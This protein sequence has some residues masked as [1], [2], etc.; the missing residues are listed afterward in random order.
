MNNMREKAREELDPQIWAKKKVYIK[1]ELNLNLNQFLS[2]QTYAS[3]TQ[4]LDLTYLQ[5]FAKCLPELDDI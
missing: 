1:L 4:T 5:P 3:S 2:N